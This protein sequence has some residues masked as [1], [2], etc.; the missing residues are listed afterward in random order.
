MYKK[1]DSE[2][3]GVNKKQRVEKQRGLNANFIFT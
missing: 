2:E 1:T 3:E